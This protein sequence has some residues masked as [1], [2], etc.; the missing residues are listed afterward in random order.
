MANRFFTYFIVTYA[1]I[2]FSRSSSRP[3]DQP[4]Q[5]LECSPTQLS[6]PYLRY[7]IWHPVILP[8]PITRPVSCYALFKWLLLPSKHPGCY[9]NR[10][11]FVWLNIDLGTLDDGLGCFPLGNRPYH[12]LPHCQAVLYSIQSSSGFGSRWRPLAQSVALPLYNFAWR[13]S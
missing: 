9:S 7:Y 4:S 3:Y 11:S 6:L 1:Y 5:L 8:R 2:F 12:L 13:C 10:T